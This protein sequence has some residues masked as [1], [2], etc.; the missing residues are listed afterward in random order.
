MSRDPAVS[1][2]FAFFQRRWRRSL[3]GSKG[4]RRREDELCLLIDR[5]ER[6]L[7]EGEVTPVWAKPVIGKSRP[8]Q[9]PAGINRPIDRMAAV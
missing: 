1:L 6:G 9:L 7:H 3:T 5:W 8:A 2:A 4:S